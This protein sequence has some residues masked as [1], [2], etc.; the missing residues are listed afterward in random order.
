MCHCKTGFE[1]ALQ[2]FIGGE[3]YQL[4]APAVLLWR[5]L[6]RKTIVLIL[7]HFD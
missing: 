3:V 7:A 2:Q 4:Q 5:R 6:L 1:I